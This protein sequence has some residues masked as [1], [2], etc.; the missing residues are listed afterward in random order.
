MKTRFIRLSAWLASVCLFL[1]TRPSPAQEQ[2]Q[3]LCAQVKIVIS[4]KLTLERV[5]FLATLQ[6]TDNDGADP[7]TDFA[8]NLTFSNPALTT[9]GVA[10]DSSSLFFVQPPTLQNVPDVNG[11][12]VI[13]PTKTATISWF[14]IPTVTAGGTTP[15][16]VRYQIGARLSGKIRGVDIPPAALL[17]FP[18]TITVAPDAQLQITYFQPRD[19]TGADPFSGQ[20]QSPIP[21]TFG[22]LVQN[23][24]YGIAHDVIIQSQQPKIVENKQHLPHVAQLLGSRVNDSSLSNANLTVNLGDL[25]P[26][27]ATK[28][29]WDMIVTFSG[30]FLSVSASF[31][32][33]DALGGQKTSLIKSVNAYLFSHEVLDDQPGKDNVRDF[34]ADTSGNLDSI[35]NLIPDSLYESQGGLYPVNLLTNA[36]VV[37][38]G[39]PFQVSLTA[40]ISGWGYM[41]LAD[42]G[43]AKL[44]IGS[45]VRSDGKVLNPNNYWTSIHYEPGSNFKDTYLNLFDLVDLGA[46]TYTIT[47]TNIAPNTTAPVTSILF[48]GSS[49]LANGVYYITPDT[50][51]YFTSQDAD[52]VSIVYSLT[53]GPFVPAY[54]FTLPNP[55]QYK[56]VYR[57]SDTSGNQ[58]TNHTATLVVSGQSS[59]GFATATVSPQ[60][61]FLA[62][63]ALSI[64]PG[65]IPIGFQAS[66]NPIPMNA[67]IDVFQ[68]V[69][70]W[71]TV[72]GIPSSPT[73]GTSATLTVGGGNVDFYVY[74]LNNTSWSAEQPAS[75]ALKLSGLASGTNTVYL[76][77]RSQYGGYL[78]PTN[79]LTVSWVVDPAAPTTVITGTPASPTSGLSAQLAV[80][81]VNVSNYRASPDYSF[82]N[83]PAPVG[84]PVILTNL[85]VGPHI[86]D[87]VGQ[88]N[89]VYQPTNNPTSVS[90][91]IDPLYGYDMSSLPKVRSVSF[92]NIG[93]GPITFNWDGRSDAGIIQAPGWYAV[94]ITISDVIGHTNFTTGLA[95]ISALSGT[96]ITLADFNRGPQ[97]P[98]ARGRWAV[99]QDQSD[100]NWEIYARD[101][102][103]S[104]APTVKITNTPL[105]QQNP[106]TDGRFV[107]WQG[108]QSNGS[109]DVY[110]DD[111]T[112]STGPSALTSTSGIDEVNPAI[113][114]PWVVYQTRPTGN[115]NAPWQ[116]AALNL[117]TSNS[118]AVSPSTQDELNPDVQAGRVVW[119][120]F[121]DVG[122]GQVYFFDL[123]N[124]VLK[125]ITTNLAG[126]YNPVIYDNWIVWQDNRNL[127]LDLYGFDF[128]RNRE[129]QITSTPEDETQPYLNGPWLIATENSLGIQTG[130]A[131]LIHLPSLLQV[132]VTRTP[133]LKSSMVLADGSVVWQETV[134]NQTRIAFSSTPSLQAVF[135]NRNLVAVTP[136]MAAYAQNAY[137][138]LSAWGTNGIGEIT[139]FT[140]LNP[141]VASQTASLTNGA[142]SGS[143]FTLVPG[144]FLW[145]KFN[146]EQVLDLGVNNNGALNLAAGANAFSYSGFPDAYSAYQM[147]RQ[148]GL[149]N[150]LGVRILDSQSGR[151][152]VAEVQNGILVG[153]DFP[154]P[155]VAVLMVNVARPVTQFKP[156]SP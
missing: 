148:I 142:P 103:S 135:Q 102:T 114:W 110:L 1:A 70:G 18:A 74:R 77:G 52:P 143:N 124:N 4:Q 152:R 44:P 40:S 76:L 26:N 145:V 12:G 90:W 97:N 21:F 100:G 138:L 93:A 75:A 141:Q 41:R 45:V 81:G 118:F 46:Y 78:D 24:G 147:L 23:V 16:G 62:G 42:P 51:V 146:G 125:R 32:H 91:I 153:D 133:T 151:W 38:S 20:V 10:T 58:E 61:A 128:L 122:A 88:I 13:G 98:Y 39:N 54:P 130:N 95:Q 9:N 111:L 68:G 73:A 131:R 86:V 112:S 71:A 89:G 66:T 87:F 3:G 105:S 14:I 132:P 144:T 29:A 94:R 48:S 101:L 19:V 120:D 109:W 50:Q 129:I 82:Y 119:Q 67:S 7:I 92:T 108:R 28:G 35:N 117:A 30:T 36:A 121:R 53:N 156:Q 126:H 64:R 99:W 25:H 150:A 34:L 134:S 33:S 83:A 72:A 104:N 11:G 154:I 127:E 80:G 79:A 57:A 85:S 60:P 31:T 5:G 27:Q 106:R 123:E 155:N 17:V 2:Q 47:Y 69:A 140:A 43:Q 63:D 115:T 149:S 8:A 59:L 96:S 55:G 136:A 6:I 65:N 84:T 37:G 113:D 22:V 15:D 49:T 107:V 139:Q 116:L 137:G 56:I